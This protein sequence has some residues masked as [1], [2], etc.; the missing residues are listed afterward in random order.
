MLAMPDWAHI[1]ALGILN[2]MVPL[3]QFLRYWS[4]E[5]NFSSIRITFDRLYHI[6]NNIDELIIFI[7]C[8]ICQASVRM[9]QCGS[10][11]YEIGWLHREML[12]WRISE[13]VQVVYS[14]RCS[15][16]RTFKI[17]IIF[18]KWPLSNLY[19]RVWSRRWKFAYQ[20]RAPCTCVFRKSRSHLGI[21][22]P[23]FQLG[24]KVWRNWCCRFWSVFV[25]S[26]VGKKPGRFRGREWSL[27]DN[28][29]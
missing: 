23:A 8:N 7:H 29:L 9:H 15:D 28:L 21:S 20:T 10:P 4:N 24:A 2:T 17:R 27:A 12:S 26:F 3:W 5:F 19:Q 16:A 18:K 25:P 6:C 22:S 14:R 13:K 11:E 1:M